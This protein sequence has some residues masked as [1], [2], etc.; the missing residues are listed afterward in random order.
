[1]RINMKKITITILGIFL[2]VTATALTFNQIISQDS[3]DEID[4]KINE[5]FSI[6]EDA[7]DTDYDIRK[8]SLD[9]KECYVYKKFEGTYK[10]ENGSYIKTDKEI[11]LKFNPERVLENEKKY[12]KEIALEIFEKE[13]ERRTNYLLSREINKLNKWKTNQNIDISDEVLDIINYKE[14]EKEIIGITK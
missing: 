3:F 5:T 12:S 8:C 1:M 14:K 4:F 7:K 9:G 10:K 11:L 13:Q 2:L 6:V